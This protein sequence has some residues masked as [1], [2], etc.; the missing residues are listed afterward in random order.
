MFAVPTEFTSVP[1]PVKALKIVVRD[2]LTGGE[3][4]A[5]GAIDDEEVASDDGVRQCFKA[6]FVHADI[7]SR[8]MIGKRRAV[9][10]LARLTRRASPR[11][12]SRSCPR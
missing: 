11:T 9:V 12:S 6:S 3:S 8:T 7:A 2:L 10:R 5:I 1:F 4:A